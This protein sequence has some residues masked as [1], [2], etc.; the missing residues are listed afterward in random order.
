M[1]HTF[2]LIH[3]AAVAGG[4]ALGAVVRW[5]VAILLNPLCLSLPLGTLAVNVLGGYLAGCAA[6][7]VLAYPDALPPALRLMLI[8]GFLGGLTTFSTFSSEVSERLLS[9]L[10]GQA[11]LI[12]FAHTIS[13]LAACLLGFYTLGVARS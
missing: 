6:A 9:G 2:S 8:T 11:A 3:F 10:Y 1:Q 4:A 13:A 5:V 12:I 7:F